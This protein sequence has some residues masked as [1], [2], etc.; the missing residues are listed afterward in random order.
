MPC[1]SVLLINSY[2]LSKPYHLKCINNLHIP[3]TQDHR[4]CAR[5]M[6]LGCYT[7][8][9]NTAIPIKTKTSEVRAIGGTIF[10]TLGL[11]GLPAFAC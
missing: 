7:D 4:G 6:L 2:K 8:V 10:I 3:P 5:Y 9:V 1:E 11:G